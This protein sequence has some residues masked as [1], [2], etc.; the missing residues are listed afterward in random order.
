ME[1]ARK[2]QEAKDTELAKALFDKE[3]KAR[4]ITQECLKMKLLR[5][6]GFLMLMMILK[7]NWMK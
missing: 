3:E 5:E 1:D 7:R 2:E 6:K 4:K